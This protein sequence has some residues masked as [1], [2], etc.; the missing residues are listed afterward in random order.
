T[1]STDIVI[2]VWRRA[3]TVA[4]RT[5]DTTVP[6][7]RTSCVSIPDTSFSSRASVNH[8]RTAVT[9]HRTSSQTFRSPWHEHQ[10]PVDYCVPCPGATHFS[11]SAPDSSP[12]PRRTPPNGQQDAGTR[13]GP[14]SGGSPDPHVSYVSPSP[15]TTAST[16]AP[17]RASLVAPTP[18]TATSERSSSGRCSAMACNVTAVT[19]AYVRILRLP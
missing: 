17:N 5:C 3:A 14:P 18:A 16:S 10:E 15:R 1:T 8:Y 6:G 7:V 11:D 2:S 19:T 4:R 9:T 12:A 13:H